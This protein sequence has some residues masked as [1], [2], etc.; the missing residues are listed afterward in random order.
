MQQGL[1]DEDLWFEMAY[2]ASTT[3]GLNAVADG[4]R[5]PLDFA[6]A[7]GTGNGGAPPLIPL[8]SYEEASGNVR[9]VYDDIKAYYAMDEAPN[10]F[11]AIADDDT[12]LRETWSYVKGTFTTKKLERSF[13]ECL[14]FAVSLT[15]KSAYGA[16]FHLRELRR[17]GV[18]PQAIREVI[19][20]T[21]LFNVATKLADALHLEPDLSPQVI[22]AHRQK[23]AP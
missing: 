20:V 2:T 13:K 21:Q 5:L 17:L 1:D 19:Q 16:D 14:A 15:G 23:A 18:S 4:L 8:L 6:G 10:V 11:K 22:K 7:A 12:Y 9:R 3:H